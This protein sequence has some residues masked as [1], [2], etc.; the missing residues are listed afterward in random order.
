[1]IRAIAS[2]DFPPFGKFVLPLLPVEK[3]PEELGE[4]HLFTGVNGTGKTRLLS[5]T[6]AIL[7]SHAALLKRVKGLT[8]DFWIYTTDAVPAPD[9][10]AQ[11][12]SIVVR[13]NFFAGWV[14]Q[15]GNFVAKLQGNPAFAYS[16]NAYVSDAKV[17]A[18]Q[19]FNGQLVM[20]VFP[21][22]APKPI[23][24]RS[25]RRLR[26]SKS[27]PRYTPKN[28]QKLPTRAIQRT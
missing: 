26:I 27:R 15:V 2:D 17:S 9:N 10:F 16:G 28:L 14:Q 3:K 4:V 20:L 5:V 23:R 8:S 1:M 11:W 13:P 22:P 12:S 6:S 19:T 18:W 24:K 25:C 7:G 21:F